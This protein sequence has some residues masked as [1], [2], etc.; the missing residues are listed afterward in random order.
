MKSIVKDL[1]ER[2]GLV[3]NVG[4]P[5]HVGDHPVY[6]TQV[7][8]DGAKWIFSWRSADHTKGAVEP[9]ITKD[10]ADYA[11]QKWARDTYTRQRATFVNE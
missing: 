11:R 1:L 3:P 4:A 10:S 8:P 7:Y 9:H 6:F 2:L 5:V